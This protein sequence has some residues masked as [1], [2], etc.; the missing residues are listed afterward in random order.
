[1]AIIARAR[2]LKKACG[3]FFENFG[4]DIPLD[5][6]ILVSAPGIGD[7]TANAILAIG[8][9]KKALALDANL[10]RVLSRLYGLK[11]KKGPK[12]LKELYSGFKNNK[13]C[14]DL[15]EGNARAYNEALMD[16]GRVYC[17]ANKASCE[18]CPMSQNCAAFQEKRPLYYPVKDH[19]KTNVT[20]EL[21]LLRIIVFKGD[22]VLAYKKSD[23]EWLS[24]Q[25]ELPSYVLRSEDKKLK[26]YPPIHFS[27]A[28]N[29]PEFKTGITKYKIINKVIILNLKELNSLGVDVSKFEWVVPGVQHLST[30]SEKALRTF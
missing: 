16:L 7:Y 19:S 13:L 4:G 23:K 5:F 10:E 6:E 8:A 11:I 28:E 18:L 17:K 1:M 21:E 24:G 26:Q 2:N 12:L 27:Y 14:P 9:N 20:H 3:H 29:L 25:W 30:A 15:E 22:K